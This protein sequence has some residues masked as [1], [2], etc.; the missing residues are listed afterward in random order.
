M[1]FNSSHNTNHGT[2]KVK[3]FNTL[4]IMTNLKSFPVIVRQAFYHAQNTESP[5]IF[6]I[7]SEWRWGGTRWRKFEWKCISLG[8]RMLWRQIL[9]SFLRDPWNLT[10][11]KLFSQFK[12]S[13]QMQSFPVSVNRPLEIGNKFTALKK[14]RWLV[15]KDWR[16][17]WSVNWNCWLR[18]V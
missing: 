11:L 7:F 1:K 3:N 9:A 18:A 12:A 5:F 17:R 6:L 13:K 14:V 16:W 15:E 10:H 2:D 4:V 8:T